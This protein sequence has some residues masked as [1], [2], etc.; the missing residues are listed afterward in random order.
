MESLFKLE[1]RNA[2]ARLF[3]SAKW[4]RLRELPL[5]VVTSILLANTG[6]LPTTAATINLSPLVAKSALVSAVDSAKRIN[7]VLALP[8]S[9]AAG[10]AQFVER[11]S[12]PKDELY[13][14]YLTPQEFASRFGANAGD[15]AALKDW[16][17]ANGLSIVHESAAR[18]FLT[19]SGT[20][21]QFQTLFKTQLNNYRSA[22]GKD[23]FSAGINPTLPEVIA[24]KAVRVIGLTNSVQTASLAKV[25]RRFGEEE[26][27][28]RI[29]TEVLGGTGPGGAY[30]AADLRTAYR[31]PEF[32]GA[33]PQTVAVFEQ[34]GFFDYDVQTY[35]KRMNLPHPA[36]T[37]VGVN[38]YDGYVYDF[39][40]ELE[41]VLD[42]DMVV[43]INPHVKEVT[44]YEDGN[45]PFGVALLDALDQVAQDNKAQILSISYGVDEVEQTSDQINAENTALTQL[46]AQGITVLA[47]SGDNGA[48]GRTGT[49]FYPA[50]L[51]APDPGSQPLV[52]SVGGTSLITGQKEV[53]VTEQAWNRLGEGDGAT[54]G[55]VSS[56]W[57]IPSWQPPGYT[58]F[59]G[60]SATYRNV[61]DVAAVGDPVTG[62]AVYSRPNGGWL[63]IGGTSA[64]SPIWAGYLSVMNAGLQSIAGGQQLGFF[65][66]TLYNV[67]W[68]YSILDGS[69]G[70]VGDYG[71]PG[72]NA[73]ALYNNCCGL[74]SLWGGG[75]GFNVLTA[76]ASGTPPSQIGDLKVV[77]G[78]NS[79]KITWTATTGATGYAIWVD[80]L[81]GGGTLYYSTLAAQTYVTN[82]TKFEVTNLVPKHYYDIKVAAVNQGGSTITGIAYYLK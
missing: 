7:V 15:Y 17:G 74:G 2:S 79:L 40:V 42:I 25:Y 19:V 71:T 81:G 56:V 43:A 27:A 58:T 20:A 36:I 52:T 45:D 44:A 26:T 41:A 51:E 8:L 73:G 60:G 65:N 72:Y 46:A 3:L 49:N 77:P 68:L 54:G 21:A 53:Y 28:P 14:K 67:Y 29:G 66:P 16:S 5:S 82:K 63:Q 18:T 37:F 39:E 47:S 59:N 9:D 31:I 4:L 30:A 61:P 55:G 38:G 76:N 70:D 48:Y 24:A 78:T 13:R 80:L 6:V 33:A 69:N 12:N 10:A 62:V 64:S 1:G 22:D 57:P 75:F 35:L 34:G 32:G 50:Q 11:V 23:F